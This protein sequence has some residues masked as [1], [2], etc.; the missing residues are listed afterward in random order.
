MSEQNNAINSL[1]HTKWNCKYH[2]VFAPKYRRKVFFNENSGCIFRLEQNATCNFRTFAISK[3]GNPI[4]WDC[5]IL[6]MDI[7]EVNNIQLATIE[8][9][10]N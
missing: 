1:A 7:F 3:Y 6:F 2:I 9:C 10:M 4:A 8:D 5:R